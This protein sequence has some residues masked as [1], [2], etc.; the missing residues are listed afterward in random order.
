M[1]ALAE[2]EPEQPDEDVAADEAAEQEGGSS[3]NWWLTVIPVLA[4]LDLIIVL[5]FAAQ[6]L[7]TEAIHPELELFHVVVAGL[8]GLVALLVVEAVLL[9]GGHPDHLED[10]EEPAP[11]PETSAAREEAPPEDDEGSALAAG[12]LET[13]ATADEVEGREV[14]EMARPPKGVV[15]AGVYS[16]TY[17]EIDPDSVLRVEELVAERT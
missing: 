1:N 8:V 13:L 16:T 6:M 15:D 10:E 7:S 4:L 17:V 11:G 14:L 2:E 9:W 12:D 5:L 3:F